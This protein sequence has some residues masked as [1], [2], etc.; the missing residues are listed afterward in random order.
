MKLSCCRRTEVECSICRE[1]NPIPWTIHSGKNGRKHRFH[2]LCILKWMA[3]GRTC[4]VCRED[5][6]HF[7]TVMSEND[8]H[9]RL[10]V[11][12]VSLS[13]SIFISTYLEALCPTTFQR[14]SLEL[15]AIPF[16][17]SLTRANPID[18]CV[19]MLASTILLSLK[20]DGIL[21][22]EL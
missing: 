18:G 3:V 2:Q 14:P 5:D 10:F 7:F 1:G 21:H 16:C 22:S 17:I 13:S 20:P 15:L 9:H 4:P 12:I 6:P 19:I 11:A 8:R